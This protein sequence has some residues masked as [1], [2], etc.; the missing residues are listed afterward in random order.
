MTTRALG[1]RPVI[2]VPVE[3]ELELGCCG[4]PAILQAAPAKA[5]PSPPPLGA[6]PCS[7]GADSAVTLED[8]AAV[9][10]MAGAAC[11]SNR[12]GMAAAAGSTSAEL[13][14]LGAAVAG[15]AGASAPER[16]WEHSVAVV[17]GT[18]RGLSAAAELPVAIGDAGAAPAEAEHPV[19]R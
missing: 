9:A 17:A 18:G 4:G 5:L 13:S 14:G 16:A 8:V 1:A 19:P 3:T 15:A 10:A 11:T 7:S 2:V 6:V 12:E